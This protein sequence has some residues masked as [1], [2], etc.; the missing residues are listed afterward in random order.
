MNLNLQEC[1]VH[2]FTNAWGIAKN[3]IRFDRAAI[4]HAKPDVCVVQLGANGPDQ[5][6][7]PGWVASTLGLLAIELQRL[8]AKVVLICEI[9]PRLNP[10]FSCKDHINAAAINCNVEHLQVVLSPKYHPNVHF[11]WMRKIWHTRE[12]VHAQDGIYLNRRG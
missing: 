9:L 10:K 5:G 12:W 1:E 6:E 11:W 7:E 4:K 2:W 8:G 3:A